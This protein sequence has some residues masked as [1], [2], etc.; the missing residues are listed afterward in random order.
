MKLAIIG[1][2]TFKNY[3]LM[4]EK[5][6]QLVDINTISTIVSGGAKGADELAVQFANQHQIELV[7]FAP[8]YQ[9]YA[10]A[11]TMIRNRQIVDYADVMIA[12]WDGKSTGTKYTINHAK[13]RNKIVHICLIE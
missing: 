8:E 2:R 3:A 1:S 4:Q 13:K 9:K 10:R 7:I 5:I 6:Q 11:A 12:F